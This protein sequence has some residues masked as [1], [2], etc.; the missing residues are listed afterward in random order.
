M[1]EYFDINKKYFDET[2]SPKDL[3]DMKSEKPN[4]FLE[5]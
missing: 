1:K 3:E 4:T 5:L 2:H